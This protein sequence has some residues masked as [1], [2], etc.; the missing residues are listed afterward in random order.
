M[1]TARSHYEYGIPVLL[2]I[3]LPGMA[4]SSGTF[5]PHSKKT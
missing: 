3:I 1:P 5:P 4:Y 2:G